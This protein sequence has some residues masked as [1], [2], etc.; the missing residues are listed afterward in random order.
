VGAP[1][2]SSDFAGFYNHLGMPIAEW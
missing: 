1:G 2:G